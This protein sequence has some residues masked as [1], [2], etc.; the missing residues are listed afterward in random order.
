M[1]R[2]LPIVAVIGQG[3]PLAA[4]RENLARETGAAIARLG[5][6]LLTGGGYG[7]MEAATEGFVAVTDRTGF[8]IGI[9]P[10]DPEGPLDQPRRDEL[11]RPYP[12]ASIEIAIL[13]PLPPHADDWRN[14]AARNHVNVFSAHAIIALPG[15][16]G[17]RNELEMAAFYRGE[18][19]RPRELRRTILIGPLE[20]FAA[21]HREQ[22][23]HA[24][25][26]A[27]AERHLRRILTAQGFA[28]GPARGVRSAAGR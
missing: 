26:L 19:E 18:A 1:L 24:G 14:I 12:N 25:S 15:D 23:V 6:H 10:R 16:V 17:T 20:E 22:F 7:V 28:L 27:E 2:K 21:A 13:T 8:S 9:V 5:A 4:G 3:S 11:G